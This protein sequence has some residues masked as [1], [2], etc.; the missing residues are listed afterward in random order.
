MCTML[1]AN[2]EDVAEHNERNFPEMAEAPP[3]GHANQQ[4]ALAVSQIRTKMFRTNVY[5]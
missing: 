3:S 1:P 4:H 2:A 5:Y